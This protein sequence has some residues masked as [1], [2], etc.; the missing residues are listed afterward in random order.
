MKRYTEGEPIGRGVSKMVF[1]SENDKQIAVA[2]FHRPLTN[3]QIKSTYYLQKL[4][5]LFFPKNTP[6]IEAAFNNRNRESF[7]YLEMGKRDPEHDK[8]NKILSQS[9]NSSAKKNASRGMAEHFRNVENNRK[10]LNFR[11]EA[12]KRGFRIDFGGQNYSMDDE[13][14]VQYLETNPGWEYRK[15]GAILYW[16]DKEKLKKSIEELPE[17]QK[18]EANKYFGR[19]ISLL[20][21]NEN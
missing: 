5:H 6:D 18:T 9:G 11:Q 3:D 8:Y 14:N 17:C 2:E 12:E 4:I 21:K 15:R 19:L 1:E 13:D 10:V 7:L 16:F 20:P